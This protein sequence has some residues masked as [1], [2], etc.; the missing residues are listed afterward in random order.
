DGKHPEIN[1]VRSEEAYLTFDRPVTNPTEINNRKII[2]GELRG[3]ITINNNRRTPR[4]DDDVVVTINGTNNPL[5]LFYLEKEHRVWTH[6]VVELLDLHPD[7]NPT[8][9][10]AQGM[11][12]YL[13]TTQTPAAG[14]H[15]K[16]P[17]A[18]TVS[19]VERIVLH[20]NVDMF[21]DLDARSGFLGS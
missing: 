4:Q 9:I 20:R 8:M 16:K 5:P 12:L 1:T 6:G 2:A 3:R 11:D 19:G 18:E 13:T 21:L 10:S 17:K 15:G 14:K 7:S